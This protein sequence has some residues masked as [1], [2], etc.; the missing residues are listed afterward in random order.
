MRR[1][2]GSEFLVALAALVLIAFAVVFGV[3]LAIT[4]E[5]LREEVTATPVALAGSESNTAPD[6]QPVE[7]PEAETLSSATE[8]PAIS[9]EAAVA[10]ADSNTAE[11]TASATVTSP[12]ETVTATSTKADPPTRVLD[13]EVRTAVAGIERATE[14]ETEATPEATPTERPTVAP[15]PTRTTLPTATATLPEPTETNEPRATST[16][17]PTRVPTKTETETV[18]TDLNVPSSDLGIFPTPTGMAIE[19]PLAV[20]VPS[21]DCVP[22]TGWIPYEVRS[23]DTL[24][25]LALATGV[26]LNTLRDANCLE[27]INRITAG[28]VLYVPRLPSGFLATTLAGGRTAEGCESPAFRITSPRPNDR[29]SQPF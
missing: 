16:R 14:K 27:D 8:T 11:P 25:S 9:T 7:S 28:E 12:D 24:F 19:T 3:L 22:P 13:A 4:S 26:G 23:D 20:T 2:L 1:N 15:R 6:D 18:E 29:F 17:R 5:E 21:G 10:T